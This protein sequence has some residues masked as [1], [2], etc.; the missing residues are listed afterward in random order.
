VSKDLG[1]LISERR[2]A[3]G[4]TLEEIGRAVGVSKSTVQRWE[5]GNIRNMRRDKLV[6]L[7]QALATSPD[8]LMGWVDT[9]DATELNE[10]GVRVMQVLSKTRAFENLI[11]AAG[12]TRTCDEDANVTIY[13]DRVYLDQTPELINEVMDDVTSYFAFILERRGKPHA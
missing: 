9:P 12:F 10:H 6:S 5:S 8:Y 7:A 11:S 1:K 2:L 13:N 4:K 3:L